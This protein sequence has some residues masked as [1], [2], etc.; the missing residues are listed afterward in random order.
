MMWRC[1]PGLIE[2]RAQPSRAAGV[3]RRMPHLSRAKGNTCRRGGVAVS[4]Y[5]NS[6]SCC[7][8]FSITNQAQPQVCLNPAHQPRTSKDP[9]QWRAC[10]RTS[11]KQPTARLPTPAP[12]RLTL[13]RPRKNTAEPQAHSATQRTFHEPR[14]PPGIDS[15]RAW[16]V[17]RS[18]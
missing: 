5:P 18:S 8:K 12:H 9:A 4:H 11:A 13:R 16:G 17:L 15:E 14:G 6:P 7:A 2:P 10:H 3:Y 1:F